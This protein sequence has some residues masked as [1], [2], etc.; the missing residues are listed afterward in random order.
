MSINGYT[1]QV[2]GYAS[3]VGSA[4]LNQKLSLERAE[5]VLDF[6]EQQGGVPMTN[7]W[8]RARWGL[9]TR[10]DPIRLPKAKRPTVVWS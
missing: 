1:M 3:A 6:L 9:R 8:H 2:Q 10:W 4:A 5:H 7:I